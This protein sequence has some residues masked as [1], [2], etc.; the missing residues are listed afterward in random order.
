[1][2]TPK[3][4]EVLDNRTPGSLI[5]LVFVLREQ[6]ALIEARAELIKAD[7]DRIKE[8]LIQRMTKSE[9]RAL[10]GKLAK[11][12]LTESEVANAKDWDAINAF[13][14]KEDAWDLRN[15]ALNQAALRARREA[16]VE[17]PGVEWFKNVKINVRKL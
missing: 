5:D 15:K 3:V 6:R 11:C 13:I 12:S 9:L 10:S 1:M 8:H 2:A 7:E 14:E 17:V 4:P 16:G